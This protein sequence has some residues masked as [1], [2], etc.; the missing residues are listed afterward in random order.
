[1]ATAPKLYP[2]ATI[3][4]IVKAHSRKA[5]SK[6]ADV[7][8]CVPVSWL[9]LS[10]YYA[11][12]VYRFSWITCCSYRSESWF[13]QFLLFGLWKAMYEGGSDRL[14]GKGSLMREASIHA[15]QAGERGIS[16]RNIK[17]V[18]EVCIP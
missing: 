12:Q 13:S 2:R 8:V 14:I 15:K 16:A 10:K 18:T 7:L 6:N 5:L 4:K 1:M 9:L 17:K 3:K 11:D